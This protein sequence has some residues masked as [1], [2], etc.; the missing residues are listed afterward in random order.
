MGS[1]LSGVDLDSFVPD[2]N[3]VDDTRLLDP[4]A[5]WPG[6]SGDVIVSAFTEDGTAIIQ[7]GH[8]NGQPDDIWTRSKPFDGDWSEW[9]PIEPLEAEP[10]EHSP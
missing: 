1:V 6:A 8:N 3:A 4:I 9:I 5:A 10:K 2:P 7:R